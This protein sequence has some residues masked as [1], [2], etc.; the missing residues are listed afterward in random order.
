LDQS[1]GPRFKRYNKIR[2]QVYLNPD[3]SQES[4]TK[5]SLEYDVQNPHVLL[6]L[7]NLSIFFFNNCKFV[8]MI[9]F[10]LFICVLLKKLYSDGKGEI[11]LCVK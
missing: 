7:P 11:T 4:V 10:Y 6:L 3:K 1:Y 2:K 8:E 9:F 5:K